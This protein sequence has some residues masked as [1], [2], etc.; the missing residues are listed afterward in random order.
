[1]RTMIMDTSSKMLIVSFLENE[2]IIYQSVLSGKNNHSDNLLKTIKTGLDELDLKVDDFDEMIVGVGPGAYTGLRV[3]LTVAKMFC[4]TLKKDLY[5]IS[6]LDL[7]S[8]GVK[9]D[10]IYVV[11]MHAK[12]DYVYHKIFEIKNGKRIVLENEKFLEKTY[13]NM[14]NEKYNVKK[15]IDQEEIM[16]NALNIKNCSLEKVND[17]F[18]L[19]PNYLRDAE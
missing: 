19:E 6:S 9:E 3:S 1:M 4:W 13:S 18:L 8:S 2:K 17:L 5:I 14:I 7:L 15:I 11:S 12:K 16:Y 10:G